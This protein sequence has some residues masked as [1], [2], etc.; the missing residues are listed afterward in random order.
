MVYSWCNGCPFRLLQSSKLT[1]IQL[2]IELLV[3]I[4]VVII[5]VACH[6]PVFILD[7]LLP[8]ITDHLQFNSHHFYKRRYHNN[9]H[10]ARRVMLCVAF[11]VLL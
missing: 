5:V 8:R 10:F 7:D 4:V 9:I 3:R 1:F 2:I 11:V 6:L